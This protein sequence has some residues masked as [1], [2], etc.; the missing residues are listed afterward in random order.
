MQGNQTSHLK[1]GLS[2]LIEANSLVDSLSKEAIIKSKELS[3]KQKEADEAL[4]GITIAMKN[5]DDRK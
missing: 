5:A 2:K 4:T 1:S 3:V